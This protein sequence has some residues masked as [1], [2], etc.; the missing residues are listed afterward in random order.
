MF[1]QSLTAR[2]FLHFTLAGPLLSCLFVRSACGM[3]IHP[4]GESE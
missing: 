1:F 2:A 3:T 4:S